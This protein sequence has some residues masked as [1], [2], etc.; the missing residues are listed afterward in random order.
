MEH[1]SFE[2][3]KT[4]TTTLALIC[5]DAVVLA[6]DRKATMGYLIA[7]KDFKK[8]FQIDEK[9]A[10][11]TAGSVGDAQVLERHLKAELKLYKLQENR[12]LNVKGAATLLANILYSR[13]YFPYWVQILIG[14]YDDSPHV[15]SLGPDG[16]IIEEKKYFST[17][18]GSPF[19]F[20]VLEKDYKD[21]MTAEEAKKLAIKAVHAA[22]QRD[23]ASGGTGID[24][25]IID[26]SGVKE[27][28]DAEVQSILSK[29]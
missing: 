1:E 21:N 16:S 29:N 12:T 5:K 14:G 24:C 9:L 25:F 22:T 3:L 6:A 2:K 20:G 23:I 27:I 4:G 15:Y 10:I 11:T 26:K 18:S 28:L 13:K 17:G 8:I 7:S 19:V